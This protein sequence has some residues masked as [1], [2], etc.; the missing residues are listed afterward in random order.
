MTSVLTVRARRARFHTPEPPSVLRVLLLTLLVACGAACGDD[1]DP[2]TDAG[3]A[4]DGSVS[5]ACAAERAQE[6]SGSCE[7]GCGV[8]ACSCANATVSSRSCF[9]GRC[10]GAESCEDVCADDGGWRCEPSACEPSCAGRACGEDDGC[11][12]SCTTCPAGQTCNTSSEQCENTGCVSQCEGRACGEDD[13]CGAS[14]TGCP[15]GQTCN[16]AERQCE[17]V[18]VPSCDGKSCGDDDTCGGYCRACP[19]GDRCDSS[20]RSCVFSGGSCFAISGSGG[21]MSCISDRGESACITVRATLG[22]DWTVTYVDG[23]E[24][25]SD[26]CAPE[27]WDCEAAFSCRIDGEEI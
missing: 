25:C 12:D 10:L 22:S 13:G 24:A 1:A 26:S 2:V 15:A 16:V 14:C 6:G 27:G 20:T 5:G 18:C 9:N 23:C 11:G 3:T 21:V 4:N 8:I 7:S 19:D 17:E